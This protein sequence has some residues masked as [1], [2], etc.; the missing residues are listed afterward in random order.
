MGFAAKF[1]K[2]HLA[3]ANYSYRAMFHEGRLPIVD[4]ILQAERA[5]KMS[6]KPPASRDRA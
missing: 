6:T 2:L 5:K 4:E 3:V 1:Q